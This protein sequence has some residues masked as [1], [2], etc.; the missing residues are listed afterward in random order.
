MIHSLS[1]FALLL[2]GSSP[3]LDAAQRCYDELDYQCAE[4]RLAEALEAD[5]PQAER[6]QALHLQALVWF[7]YSDLVGAR[8]AAQALYAL[9]PTFT[10][11]DQ[12]PPTLRAV[13]IELQP[14]PPAPPPALLI[15]GHGASLTLSGQDAARWS[16]GLGGELEAGLRWPGLDASL[17]LTVG[18]SDHLPKQIADEGMWLG[19]GGLTG[20]L[21]A[22]WGP[23]S[24][25]AGITLGAARV[26]ID[27]ALS[28]DQYWGVWG[29]IPLEVAWPLWGGLAVSAQVAP[30]LFATAD[31]DRLAGSWLLPVGLGLRFTSP[32]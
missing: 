8:R 14:P 32:E 22:G 16:G 15:R 17:A 27:G 30:G 26:A 19:Y 5:L 3:A 1:A 18:V 25:S 13:F 9:D 11:D 2:T 31:G 4:R 28:D 20:R 24:C 29:Q 21:Y 12:L 23:L 7:A 6:V 10:P